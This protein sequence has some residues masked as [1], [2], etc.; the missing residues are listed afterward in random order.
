VFCVKGFAVGSNATLFS[1]SAA[2]A[3]TASSIAASAAAPKRVGSSDARQTI[4]IEKP[5]KEGLINGIASGRI[6]SVWPH[7]PL[8]IKVPQTLSSLA[9]S[10][11]RDFPRLPP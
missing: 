3:I 2:A 9:A 1:G 8:W 5:L 7:F 11:R 6:D 10:S 4:V